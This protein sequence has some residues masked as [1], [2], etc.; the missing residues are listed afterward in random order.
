MLLG[1]HAANRSRL[2]AH[3]TVD[4][5]PLAPILATGIPFDADDVR[6]HTVGW[7]VFDRWSVVAP[8]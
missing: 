1:A 6:S 7:G 3:H 8:A 4:V 2:G 5:D